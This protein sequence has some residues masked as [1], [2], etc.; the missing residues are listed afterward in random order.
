MAGAGSIKSGTRRA[1][2]GLQRASGNKHRAELD[3]LRVTGDDAGIDNGPE[4]GR[5]DTRPGFLQSGNDCHA[6][7]LAG[8]GSDALADISDQ[9]LEVLTNLGAGSVGKVVRGRSFGFD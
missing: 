5:R 2:D 3:A 9:E 7:D 4:E 6:A 1:A 8:G